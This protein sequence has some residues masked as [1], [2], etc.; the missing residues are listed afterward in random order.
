MPIIFDE[1]KQ[2]FKLDSSGSTY[3]FMVY[4][5]GYLAHLYYGAK[6]SDTDLEYLACFEPHGAVCPRP[7]FTTKSYFSQDVN[8]FEYSCNGT[9]DFRLSAL[10][11]RTSQGNASTDIRYSAHRIYKGKPLIP[12]LPAT[13]ASDDEAMTLEIDALDRVS[14]A[15]VTLYYTVFEKMSAITR[16][17]RVENTSGEPLE[18]ERIYSTC[19]D[20][21]SGKYDLI[22]LYGKWGK[23]CSYERR[24]LMHG[25]QTIASKRGASSHNHNP[26]VAVVTPGTDECSGEAYGFSFVYSGN[27]AADIELDTFESTRLIMGINP[28]DFSWNLNPGES[29]HT[30]EVV[31]V[32]SN[33]GI[34]EMSRIYHKLYRNNLVRGEWK[35]KKRPVLINNWEATYFDFNSE[36]LLSITKESAELGIEMLVMDDGWFGKRNNSRSSLGD[37]FVNEEKLPGGLSPLVDKVNA[38][39]MKFGIW[40]E[41]EMVSPDSELYR[42]HPDWCLHVKGR[43]I[44]P[45]RNQYVLDM[46][47]ADVRDYL[48]NCISKILDG[49]NIEYI[50][51]DFNRPLTEVGSALLAPSQQKEIFHRYVLGLY[52]LLD[53][54]TKAYPHLLLEGCASG[55]GRFDPG[56]LYYFPQYWTSDDTDA[57]E[58]IDIQYGTSMVYPASSMSAHVS[59][60]PNHQTMRTTSFE[61]RGNI[62][63]SGVFGYELD[64]NKL[65]EKEKEITKKQISDYNKYYDVIHNGELHRLV[66]PYENRQV[67]AWEYVTEDKTKAVVTYAVMRTG[68]HLPHNIRLRGLDADKKYLEHTSGRIYSGDTLMNAGVSFPR[69]FADF[70][71]VILYFTATEN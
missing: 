54:I 43:E 56:M 70:E 52:E 6:I 60:C 66:S 30:P 13:Y 33:S 50:K 47:R 62:A 7:S 11:I 63:M 68:I 37:W 64:I 24:P 28:C 9:G 58:R 44:S 2:V 38:L 49:A 5:G 10:Q 41:P 3:A 1:N 71:S 34:G 17:I 51:W 59:A 20:F 15:K 21:N 45:S 14:G 57:I 40:F 36:K 16:H 48:F 8:R 26:F 18:L 35:Y 42:A 53:R 25:I 27:F 22:H 4:E 65:T 39:G 12:S 32:Y 67:T 19:V 61:T 31:M 69:K 46:T 23:E 55:G 29:F